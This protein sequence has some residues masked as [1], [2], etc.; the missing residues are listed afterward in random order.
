MAAATRTETEIR[1]FRIETP[2]PSWKTS[3]TA[4]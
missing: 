3:E 4:W 1:P 2:E